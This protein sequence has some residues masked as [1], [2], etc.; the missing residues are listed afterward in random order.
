MASG[1]VTEKRPTTIENDEMEGSTMDSNTVISH[2]FSG[3][4]LDTRNN[5][6]A[7]MFRPRVPDSGFLPYLKF[8][9]YT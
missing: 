2:L 5:G 9:T 4:K 8:P 3:N 6:T 1:K 7:R